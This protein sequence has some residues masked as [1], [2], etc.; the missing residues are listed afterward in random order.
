MTHMDCLNFILSHACPYSKDETTQ[1]AEF[2]IQLHCTNVN[3]TAKCLGNLKYEIIS[4]TKEE[5]SQYNGKAS[6]QNEAV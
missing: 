6:F 3:V 4:V 1:I 2:Q 5:S